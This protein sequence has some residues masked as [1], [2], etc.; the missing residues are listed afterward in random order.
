MNT[1]QLPRAGHWSLFLCLSILPLAGQ[2]ATLST[3]QSN[4]ARTTGNPLAPLQEVRVSLEGAAPA[5]EVS[6][7]EV[8]TVNGTEFTVSA[9]A[10]ASPEAL[11][12]SSTLSATSGGIFVSHL[13]QVIAAVTDGLRID[14]ALY[15]GLTAR[16]TYALD[17]SG[18]L[19]TAVIAEGIPLANATARW[20][21]SSGCAAASQCTAGLLGLTPGYEG[22]LASPLPGFAIPV[23]DEPGLLSF[24][25]EAAFGLEILVTT[26]LEMTTQ[27]LFG[28]GSD[29]VFATATADFANTVVWGGIQSVVLEDGTI[30]TDWTTVSGSGFDYG[31]ATII[32][33]PAAGWLFGSLLLGLVGLKRRRSEFIRE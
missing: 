31:S 11:R 29:G 6:R 22:S 10:F 2:A 12:A 25:I 21:L 16:V 26:V 7:D 1:H 8:F 33:L 24:T 5:A 17:I 13:H 28:N 20:N 18:M 4:L 27:L 19:D 32:P 15:D 3:A 9:Y 23:G 14:S 30:V